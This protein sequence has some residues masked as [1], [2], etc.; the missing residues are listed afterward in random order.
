MGLFD[1]FRHDVSEHWPAQTKQPLTLDLRKLS[2][3]GIS[4]GAPA[5]SLEQFGRPSN[6]LPFK[7][8]R[9]LYERLGLVIEVESEAVDYL[10]L[11][12]IGVDGRDDEAIRDC[13]VELVASNGQQMTVRDGT[14]AEDVLVLLPPPVSTETEE[15]ET[16][17]YFDTGGA[18]LELEGAPSGQLRRLNLFL[19]S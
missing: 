7:D 4:L 6:R 18:R 16:V 19:D 1:R 11:V 13:T 8:G 9:F 5:S 17:Y 2:L 14:R 3:N 12:F 10:G 15:E